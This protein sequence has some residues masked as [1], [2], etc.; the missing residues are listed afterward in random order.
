MN[1][2]VYVFATI[3][4]VATMSASAIAQEASPSVTGVVQRG[5]TTIVF[6]QTN[7]GLNLDQLDA[8]SQVA[9]S[10][11]AMATKLARNPSLVNNEGFVSKHPAL[12]QYLEKYPSAREDIAANPGNYLVPVAGSG[13]SHA[14][15][16]VN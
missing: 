13:W 10:D 3:A 16:G 9:S 4:I 6:Q 11:P 2:L 12:Q 14:A 8:F 1:R 5:N 7:A 15:P